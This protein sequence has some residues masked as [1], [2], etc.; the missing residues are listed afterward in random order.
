[1]AT[2]PTVL[3]NQPDSK[4]AGGGA[5]R[6]RTQAYLG[7]AAFYDVGLSAKRTVTR[8]RRPLPS[9]GRWSTGAPIAKSC[10]IQK[11]D[12][13]PSPEAAGIDGQSEAACGRTHPGLR[14][15]RAAFWGVL[16]GT[17]RKAPAWFE[18]R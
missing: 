6:V 1:M 15:G 18:A 3:I 14:S 4:S 11:R 8:D 5:L 16:A 7:W 13:K 9:A 2:L 12:R 10:S 17:T